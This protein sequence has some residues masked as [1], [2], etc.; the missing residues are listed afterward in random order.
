MILFIC[1]KQAKLICDDRGQIT[2]YLWEYQQRM[3]EEVLGCWEYF[4]MIWIMVH[5]C[6]H[7]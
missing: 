5:G 6:I 4:I 2:G 7:I 1:P 3:W